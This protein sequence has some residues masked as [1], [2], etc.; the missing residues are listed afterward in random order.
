MSEINIK[1][2]LHPRNRHRQPYDF[3]SMGEAYPSLKTFLSKNKYG[4]TSINF[5]DP[6]AVKLLNTILLKEHYELGYFDIPSG[7]L[8]PAIPGRADYI[9]HIADLIGRHHKDITCLDIGTG[10]N[11]VYPIIATYEYGWKCI[12]TDIDTRALSSAQQII[13]NNPRLDNNVELRLQKNS[14]YIFKGVIKNSDN[15]DIAICNPP[16]YTSSSAATAATRRKVHNLSGKRHLQPVKNFGGQSNELWCRGGERG[17][18]SKMIKE[19]LH[20]AGTIKWF[21]TLVSRSDHLKTC[22]AQVNSMPNASVKIIELKT[23]NKSSHILAWTFQ[24]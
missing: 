11:M 14:S 9:H 19:S 24:N 3:Q 16:F 23:G 5:F 2:F 4:N 12:G 21:T 18:I 6:D 8:C 13:D 10:A 15:I 17:F 22:S 7:Y 20:Y 1:S